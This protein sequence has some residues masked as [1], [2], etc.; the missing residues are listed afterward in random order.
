LPE[1]WLIVFFLFCFFFGQV[2]SPSSFKPKKKTARKK[3]NRDRKEKRETQKKEKKK[4]VMSVF[5]S[6][7][8]TQLGRGFL[9]MG[10]KFRVMLFAEN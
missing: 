3:N 6:E 10:S 5:V 4:R 2:R 9:S 8:P 1:K 7:G